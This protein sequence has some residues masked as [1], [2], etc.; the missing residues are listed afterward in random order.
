[1]H[2][3]CT[4]DDTHAAETPAFTNATGNRPSHERS[5]GGMLA[6]TAQLTLVEFKKRLSEIGNRRSSNLL[7]CQWTEERRQVTGFR[8]LPVR[9]V[10]ADVRVG[11]KSATSGPTATKK[12]GG[13]AHAREI[14]RP[15]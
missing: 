6:G 5:E 11:A 2:R 8:S 4:T 3:S 14:A 1:M 10:E 7:G 13:S 12:L 9:R 15:Q